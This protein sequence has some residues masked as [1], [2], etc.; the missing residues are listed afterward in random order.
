MRAAVIHSYKYSS[1][2][3]QVCYLHFCAKWQTAVSSRHRVFVKN[4]T[5]GGASAVKLTAIIRGYSS[6]LLAM[7]GA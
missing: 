3:S 6:H 1:S 2:V 7:S 4:F 5:A